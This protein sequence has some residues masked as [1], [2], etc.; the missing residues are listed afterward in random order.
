MKIGVDASRISVSEKTGTENY[1]YNLIREMV[2]D[3]KDEFV[4][5]LRGE[6]PEFAEG[7]N[8]LSRKIGLPRLWTQVGLAGEVLIHP[9]DVLFVPAHTIPVVRRPDLRTVVTIH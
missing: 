6:S 1:S 5:Y 7:K 4:L 8:V 2:K 9:P 3:D